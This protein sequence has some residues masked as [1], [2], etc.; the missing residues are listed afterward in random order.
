MEIDKA[1]KR[2]KKLQARLD[3]LPARVTVADAQKARRW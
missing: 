2:I 3:S 1:M